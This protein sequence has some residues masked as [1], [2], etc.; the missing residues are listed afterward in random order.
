MA[1]KSR[2][3]REEESHYEI[4]KAIAYATVTGLCP[5]C[6]E[7]PSGWTG[8]GGITCGELDCVKA[9]LPG[10]VK[11]RPAS[12]DEIEMKEPAPT[13][14]TGSAKIRGLTLHTPWTWLI[15]RPDVT[16]PE[17][18][19]AYWRGG[20]IK[21]IENRTWHPPKWMIGSYIAIHAGKTYDDGVGRWLEETGLGITLPPRDQITEG[22]IVAVAQLLN[23]FG[24][25]HQVPGAQLP[26]WVG[27]VGWYLGQP[28]PIEPVPCRGKQ[29]VWKLDPAVLEQVRRRYQEAMG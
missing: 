7:R 13:Y 9:W 1:Y 11:Y 15:A 17:Q 24:D 14:R 21:A 20:Q 28:V 2:V 12:G 23:V 4:G 6:K 18:R 10:G 5:V 27:P 25:E 19:E 29:G 3:E 26:W 16:D 22:A 8:T